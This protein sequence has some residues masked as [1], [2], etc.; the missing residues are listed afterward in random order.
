MPNTQPPDLV[1]QVRWRNETPYIEVGKVEH[2]RK[3]IKV[4]DRHGS[5]EQPRRYWSLTIYLAISHEIER[6]AK[7]VVNCRDDRVKYGRSPRRMVL[8]ET[9]M[10][11]L[12]RLRRTLERH[13]INTKP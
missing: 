7:S 13:G 5:S 11:K 9:A 12:R 2:T 4:W 10:C 1:F 8:L 3:S 6:W